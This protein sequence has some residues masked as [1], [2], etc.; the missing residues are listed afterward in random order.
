MSEIPY[1]GVEV[2][3]FLVNTGVIDVDCTGRNMVSGVLLKEFMGFP[4]DTHVMIQMN[5][6]NEMVFEY[7][8]DGDV[9]EESGEPFYRRATKKFKIVEDV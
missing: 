9:N 3:E 8:L 1:N 5:L 2:F 6:D 7:S 4:T